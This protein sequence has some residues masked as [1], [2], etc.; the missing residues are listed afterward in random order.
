MKL[1]LYLHK[2]DYKTVDKDIVNGMTLLIENI[3]PN[4]SI[5]E[6]KTIKRGEEL[7]SALIAEDDEQKSITMLL[8]SADGET[9]KNILSEKTKNQTSSDETENTDVVNTNTETNIEDIDA[10]KI[11]ESQAENFYDYFDQKDNSKY[12]EL[13][14]KKMQQ[15]ELELNPLDLSGGGI[16]SYFQQYNNRVLTTAEQEAVARQVWDYFVEKGWDEIHIAGVLGNFQGESSMNPGSIESNGQGIGLAQWSF[17]RKTALINYAAS[18]GTD[19]SDLQTQLDFLVE[20]D[21]DA[22]TARKYLSINFSSISD[23]AYWWAKY[24]ERPA[25]WALIKSMPTR[26]GAGNTYYDK[27]STT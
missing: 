2:D 1:L 12:E 13:V 5:V 24:W 21:S 25:S 15:E 16:L 4:S 7:G 10:E 22:P 8:K 23:A 26:A 6:G 18:R 20:A 17:S 14:N 27:F 3:S 19:W 11:Y 9:V